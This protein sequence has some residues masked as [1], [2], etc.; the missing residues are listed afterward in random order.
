[1]SVILYID[2]IKS[3]D[4]QRFKCWGNIDFLMGRA[5]ESCCKECGFMEVINSGHICNQPTAYFFLDCNISEIGIIL[6]A[7]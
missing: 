4:K 5:A 1:M 6:N 2:P 3:Q 7:I